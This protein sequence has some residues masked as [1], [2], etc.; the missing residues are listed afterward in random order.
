MRHLLRGKVLLGARLAIIHNTHYIQTLM[1]D[2]RE[3]IAANRLREFADE[4]YAKRQS[5]SKKQG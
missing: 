4:W 3:A 2:I 5:G 1:R